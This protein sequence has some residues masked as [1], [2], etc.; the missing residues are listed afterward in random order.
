M[1]DMGT[2]NFQST[3][4]LENKNNKLFWKL[5]PVIVVVFIIGYIRELIFVHINFQRT[6]VYYHETDLDYNYNFPGILL[7]LKKLNY[8]QLTELKWILTVLFFLIYFGITYFLVSKIFK[9]KSYNIITI[10]CHL[11]FFFVA[12][13]FYLVGTVTGKG[14]EGYTLSREFMG[15]LQSPLL[16]MILT[17]TFILGDRQKKIQ[18]NIDR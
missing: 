3:S 1:D 17:P 18:K 6:Q 13:I 2:K 14:L 16:L 11:V 10:A 8:D 7:F 4:S 9:N 12:G 15:I 5:I